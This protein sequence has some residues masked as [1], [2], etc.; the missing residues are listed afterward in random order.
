MIYSP[1]SIK[2]ALGMLMTGA[3][4]ET[5][6]Q[7]NDI[8]GKYKFHKFSDS[9]N[10]SFAN[11]LFIKNTFKDSIKKSY[12]ESLTKN[13]GADVKYDSFESPDAINKYVSKKTFKLINNLVDNVSDKDFIL[14]NALAIDMN[15]VHRLQTLSEDDDNSVFSFEPFG[16]YPEHLDYYI[17][18]EPLNEGD[19]NKLV[20]NDDETIRR[21]S[22]EIGAVLDNY[23]I[24]KILGKDKIKKTVNDAYKK[25]L[26]DKSN[27]CEYDK[28][29][30]KYVDCEDT[31][32]DI[33]KYIK[34]LD[35]YYGTVESSTDFELYVDN[36]VKVFKKN[37][38][39]YNG[40]TLQYVGIMPTNEKLD[41]YINR[42]TEEDINK[43]IKS[44]KSI[45][46]KN[47]KAGVITEI[48]GYIPLFN[49]NYEL[50]LKEDLIK[51]GVSDV[52]DS[53]KSNLSNLTTQKSYIDEAIH[54]ATIEFTNDGI[55]AAAISAMSGR[56]AGDGGF[57]YRFEPPVEKIDITFNQPFLFLIIDKD[58]EEVWFVGRVYEPDKYKSFSKIYAELHPDENINYFDDEDDSEVDETDDYED[59]EE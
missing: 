8:L 11:A 40:K 21:Q 35:S 17:A 10:M 33:N 27:Y 5:K 41:N 28:K 53:E 48:S 31:S 19:Y 49:F 54:K 1:L 22:V 45:K 59:D 50:N 43:L 39:K 18:I 56:G 44:T 4:G 47:F 14:L 32:F 55:K 51:L 30:K 25:W 15:W 37:L 29:K 52:F 24:V 36:D 46:A 58:T 3:D 6:K 2:Y 57:N 12:V 20:F 26:N 34:E 38:R 13:F 7:I 9:K 16:F 23:D 42:I